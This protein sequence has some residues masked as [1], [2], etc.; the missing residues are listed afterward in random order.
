MQT[1]D[2]PVI[3]VSYNSP[4]LIEAL[5]RTFRQFYPNK[6]YII[7]GSRPDVAAQIAQIAA[8]YDNVVFIPFGYNIHHGPGMTWAV[9][10]LGLQDQALFLDSDVEVVRGGFIESLQA[11]L[12][13]GMWG[14]GSTQRVNEQGYD[15]LEDGPVHYLHPACMLVNLPVLRQWP[16]PIKHGAPNIQAMLALHRSGNAHLFKHVEW[17][18]HDF[19]SGE[20]PNYLKH[21]WQGTVR[22]TGGYHYDM[23]APDGSVDPYMLHFAPGDAA[24]IVDVGCGSGLFA[25]AYRDMHPI[26]QYLGVELDPGLANEARPHCDFVFNMD[27]AHPTEQFRTYTAGADCWILG[28]VLTSLA[29]PWAL[30]ADIRQHSAPGTRIVVSL[31]NFQHWSVQA[32]LAVGDLRYQPDTL[33]RLTDLRLFTRG[34]LMDMLHRAGFQMIAGSPVIRD[35]P[36]R[37]SW[38]PGIRA[39]AAAGGNDPEQAAQDASA[40]SYVLVAAAV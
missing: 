40:W 29:D 36:A 9:H 15:R 21:P 27:I 17:V 20:A 33:P 37:D 30:L 34:T 11:E 23:P 24:K 6:V 26:C 14:V 35:E 38:L 4:D 39:L 3:T 19:W 2:I 31:P 18:R 5:L 8:R 13:P 1:N 16:L 12:E 7:D 25:K 10:N 22:R 28:D 32:R